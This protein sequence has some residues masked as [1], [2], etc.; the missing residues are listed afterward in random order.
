[1]IDVRPRRLD[2]APVLSVDFVHLGKVGHVGKEDVDFDGFV[3]TG[4]GGRED[5]G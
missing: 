2:F 4:A 5:C 3:D 1:M